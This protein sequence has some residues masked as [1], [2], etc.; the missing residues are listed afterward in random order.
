MKN[1]ENIGGG[2]AEI[3]QREELQVLYSGVRKE[4]CQTI[5]KQIL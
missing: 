4:G 5:R 1:E 2:G 3:T